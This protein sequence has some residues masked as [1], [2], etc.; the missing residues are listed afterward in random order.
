VAPNTKA[1]GQRKAKGSLKGGASFIYNS[2]GELLGEGPP[3][4]GCSSLT[5]HVREEIG[6]AGLSI[7]TMQHLR[8]LRKVRK[9]HF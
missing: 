8:K 5:Q 7:W 1:K 3:G 2:Q 6:R 9:V 4:R